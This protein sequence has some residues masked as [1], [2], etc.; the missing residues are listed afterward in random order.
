MLSFKALL[1]CWLTL[2]AT[3]AAQTVAPNAIY[4]GGNNSTNSTILLNIG[5]GGAGQSGLVGGTLF[6]P[7]QCLLCW[8][9]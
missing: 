9:T 1:C 8:L 4:D 7:I 3:V 2:A 6:S 5:N